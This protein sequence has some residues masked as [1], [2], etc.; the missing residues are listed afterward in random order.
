LQRIQPSSSTLKLEA[1]GA[2]YMC[3][4]LGL[5]PGLCYD[6]LEINSLGY[7]WD[8][9]VAIKYTTSVQCVI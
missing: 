4:A 5:N 9:K 8:F 7:S 6:R 1:V 2:S 3:T